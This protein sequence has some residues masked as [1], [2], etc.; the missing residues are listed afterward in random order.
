MNNFSD[1]VLAVDNALEDLYEEELPEADQTFKVA[2][3]AIVQSL[4][5]DIFLDP[6]LVGDAAQKTVDRG[7]VEA[8][9]GG[10]DGKRWSIA[11]N[12]SR[13]WKDKIPAGYAWIK[14]RDTE[15]AIIGPWA[16]VRTCWKCGLTGWADSNHK[17]GRC[18]PH[19]PCPHC[20][21]RDWFGRIVEPH[22]FE[23]DM[24]EYIARDADKDNLYN[25]F[26]PKNTGVAASSPQQDHSPNSLN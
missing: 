13:S 26:A 14:Y 9:M 19:Y 23:R 6:T 18:L 4:P 21:E 11:L 1:R 24:A 12:W 17:G 25:E 20:G 3:Q 7:L 16:T 5:Y 2:L 22:H 15:V 8:H 10:E